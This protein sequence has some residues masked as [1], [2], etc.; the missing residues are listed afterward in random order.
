MKLLQSSTTFKQKNNHEV[1]CD[2]D[3]CMKLFTTPDSKN[4]IATLLIVTIR[5]SELTFLLRDR[6]LSM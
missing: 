4:I 2:Q 6:T 1:S 3:L 5:K